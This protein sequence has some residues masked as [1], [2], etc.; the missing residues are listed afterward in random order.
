MKSIEELLPLKYAHVTGKETIIDGKYR[1]VHPYIKEYWF[2]CVV[3]VRNGWEHVGVKIM[4]IVSRNKETSTSTKRFPTWMEM[5]HIRNVFWGPQEVVLQFH[6][7]MRH[8]E[9]TWTSHL[10][11]PLTAINVPEQILTRRRELEPTLQWLRLRYPNESQQTYYDV[12]YVTVNSLLTEEG[13]INPDF[14]KEVDKLIN[15]HGT[16]GKNSL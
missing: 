3:Q 15:P 12:A 11:N 9:D 13:T 7:P 10:W 14:E 4:R 1:L 2:D 16:L 5:N 8:Y 6:E